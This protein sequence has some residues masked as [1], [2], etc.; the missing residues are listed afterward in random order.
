MKSGFKN[1]DS[2]GRS[3]PIH[4]DKAQ[5][6]L[7]NY[8][9]RAKPAEN[10]KDLDGQV[11]YLMEGGMRHGRVPIGDGAVD[12]ESVMAA[13]KF[14]RVRSTNTIAYLSA[15]EENE[16]LKVTCEKLQQSN[17]QLKET[18]QI[19]NE[20]NV[21]GRDLALRLYADL[22]REAPA[23]L[24]ARLAS[25]EAGRN[26]VTGSSHVGSC[27]DDMHNNQDELQTDSDNDDYVEGEEA[28]NDMDD[29]DS[30]NDMD[31]DDDDVGCDDM[32]EEGCD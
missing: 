28:C 24:L 19:L 31:D 16:Q 22:N 8:A 11:L 3:A 2:T 10:S 1:V 26:Q 7:N 30:C 13:A 23:D 18:N 15:I 5:Q 20:E 4:N 21:V 6:R 17:E 14:N 12:K 25:L 32:D 27:Q 9:A 29:E